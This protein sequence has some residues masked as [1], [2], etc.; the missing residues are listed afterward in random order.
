MT[1]KRSAQSAKLVRP[2]V[3]G[4]VPRPRLFDLLD[5]WRDRHSGVWIQAPPGAGKTLLAA[6]YA[7]RCASPVLW[8]RLDESDADPTAFFADLEQL[9]R[10]KLRRRCAL[11]VFSPEYLGDVG[12]FA[13]AWTRAA[14]RAP[15]A[16]SRSPNAGLIVLDDVHEL[17]ARAP[18]LEA[19]AAVCESLPPGYSVLFLARSSPPAC[20]DGLLARQSIHLPKAELLDFDLPEV[21][22]LAQ[23]AGAGRLD[24]R[25]LHALLALTG[26]WAAPLAVRLRQ[27]DPVGAARSE[28]PVM[29]EALRMLSPTECAHL[30]ATCALDS[31]TRDDAVAIAADVDAPETFRRLAADCYLVSQ[32][33][34]PVWRVHPLLRAFLRERAQR[35]RGES[36]LRALQGR[37]AA[38]LLETG[39]AAEAAGLLIESEDWPALRQAIATSA[40]SALAEGRHLQLLHWIEALPEAERGQDPWL[41]YWEGAARMPLD[42]RCAHER[43]ARAHALFGENPLGR[44]LTSAGALAA[45]L[46]A[47]DDCGEVSRWLVELEALDGFRRSVNDPELDALVLASATAAL[48]TH[49]GHPLLAQWAREGARILRF[50]PA[51]MQTAI[52]SFLI[53]DHVY[54]GDVVGGRVLLRTLEKDYRRSG[55]MFAMTRHI[56]AAVLAFLSADHEAA[57]ASIEEGHR[58][59]REYGLVFFEPQLRGQEVYTALSSG[60][61]DRAAAAIAAMEATMIP[62]R[63]LDLAFLHHA[64]SGLLLAR[65]QY[66]EARREAER[67]LEVSESVH[68]FANATLARQCLAQILVRQGEWAQAQA[69][70]DQVE[71]YCERSD[72]P[73]VRFIARL[74][75]ADGHLCAG[76]VDTAAA[77]LAESLPLAARN[78][79]YNPH[80]FWQP[81]PMARLCAL[82]LER[83]IEPAYVRRLIELRRLLAPPGVDERWPWPVRIRTLGELRIE[84]GGRDLTRSSKGQQKPLQL[85]QTLVALNPEG[86]S[87]R[88]LA[89]LLWPD[90]DADAAWHAFEVTLARLRRSLGRPEALA[91]STGV[92]RIERR[93]CWVDRLALEDVLRDIED[94][95]G[96]ADP[97][98]LARRLFRVYRGELLSGLDAPWALVARQQLAARIV[99]AV[100]R[101][102][103]RLEDEGQRPMAIEN[104][105]RALEVD[106]VAENVCRRLMS[107]LVEEGRQTEALAAYERCAA[108]CELYLGAPPSPLTRA[109]AE[110]LRAQIPR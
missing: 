60:D 46:F 49:L 53:T 19:L 77:I 76:E 65:Q 63:R 52:A 30:I 107:A 16:R 84:T 83:G 24:T 101:I 68:A 3:R 31:V 48:H 14:F 12:A 85:L 108:A 7:D 29:E 47:W 73:L 103:A 54:H 71:Q 32:T 23:R 66:A 42:P 50:A 59:A 33:T 43:M 39:R 109:L 8:L 41:V 13:N 18:T 67:A 62:H 35:D 2:S 79:Y 75:R 51:G 82:A 94:G 37:T 45:I 58:L 96:N 93:I 1:A 78:D 86:T 20:F 69:H 98:P 26:G 22:R 36:G 105:Q 27:P 11:P 9:V 72:S 102:G 97:A 25:E 4:A 55:P 92:L 10:R 5:A 56:Y 70:L 34:G 81:E 100:D 104:Y 28:A 38:R 99:R 64:R 17:P 15:G 80:P 87:A 74:T 106:P 6:T 89:D 44:L 40:K 61:L 88:A 91:L 95:D 57:W 21:R 90:S 110:G